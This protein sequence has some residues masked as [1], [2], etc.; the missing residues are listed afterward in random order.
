MRKVRGGRGGEEGDEGEG[1]GEGAKW[2]G[3]GLAVPSPDGVKGWEVLEV[4]VSGPPRPLP[5]DARR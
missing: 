5:C 3:D 1:G 2:E 4:E